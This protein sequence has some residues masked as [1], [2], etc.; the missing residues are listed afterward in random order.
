MFNLCT[1]IY[2]ISIRSKTMWQIYSQGG[3]YT[4]MFYADVR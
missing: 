1:F 2:I 4:Q 3:L